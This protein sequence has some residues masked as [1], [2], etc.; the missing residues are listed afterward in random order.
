MAAPLDAKLG[1]NINEIDSWRHP[2]LIGLDYRLT[3][4]TDLTLNWDTHVIAVADHVAA[5]V[6]F[7][8]AFGQGH[9]LGI[10]AAAA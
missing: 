4:R 3:I 10:D 7:C 5:T 2:R 6:L 1:E 9:A 8:F